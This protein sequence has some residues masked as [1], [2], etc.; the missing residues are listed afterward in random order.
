MKTE[1][2]NTLKTRISIY[3]EVITT[4]A[5]GAPD[6]VKELVKSCRANQKEVNVG[7]EEDGKVRALFST[8]FLVRYDKELIKG[9]ANG[10]WIIDIDGFVYNILSVVPKIDKRYLQINTDRRE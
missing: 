6:K 10:F 3:K 8:S 9:K 2:V 7:E 4:S 5:T 1:L